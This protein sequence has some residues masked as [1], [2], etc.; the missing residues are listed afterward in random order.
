M[1]PEITLRPIS[2][3][4]FLHL[5]TVALLGPIKS[6]FISSVKNHTLPVFAYGYA[7][8]VFTYAVLFSILH[9][10]YETVPILK[11]NIILQ[12]RSY[13]RCGRASLYPR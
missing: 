13:T 12:Y 8:C 6:V 7:I 4:T 9:S 11:Y 5:L 3:A 10:L 1:L 2:P